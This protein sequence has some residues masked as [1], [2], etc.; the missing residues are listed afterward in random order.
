MATSRV[1]RERIEELA[2]QLVEEMGEVKEEDGDCWLDAIENRA[3]EIG[4]AL[5]AALVQQRSQDRPVSDEATC[6]A[7]GRLGRYRGSRQRDL[8]SRRGPI[9]LAEPEYYCPG[10]RKA[11]FPSDDSDWG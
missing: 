10:C 5:T 3:I 11:F 1:I 6:P 9:C 2:R 7:C 8:I 4:D